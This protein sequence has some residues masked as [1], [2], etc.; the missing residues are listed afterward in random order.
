MQ[1]YILQSVHITKDTNDPESQMKIFCESTL[2]PSYILV[3]VTA[4]FPVTVC[5][6]HFHAEILSIVL[7]HNVL[8]HKNFIQRVGFV[9]R[10][11]DVVSIRV[12]Q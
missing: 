3:H 11:D 9:E 4:R 2:L 1:N 7:L 10:R 5:K 8:Y 12:L 6:I